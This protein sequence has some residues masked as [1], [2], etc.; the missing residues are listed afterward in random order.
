MA[1]SHAKGC[2][3]L[4]KP[5]PEHPEVF[6]RGLGPPGPEIATESTDKLAMAVSGEQERGS[7]P[8]KPTDFFLI[9]LVF[10]FGGVSVVFKCDLRARVG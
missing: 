6:P 5:S 4:G 3:P 1:T 9:L 2:C 8:A 7:L 10:V